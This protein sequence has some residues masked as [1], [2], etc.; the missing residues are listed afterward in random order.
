MISVG[1]LFVGLFEINLEVNIQAD[2]FHYRTF[3]HMCGCICD[4]HI[5]CIKEL[6][7]DCDFSTF[8]SAVMRQ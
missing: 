5:N 4:L 3:I 6:S 2:G 8:Y 7:Q 1:L